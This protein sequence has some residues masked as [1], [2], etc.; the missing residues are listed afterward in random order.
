MGSLFINFNQQME[1]VT[2]K[3]HIKV[4]KSVQAPDK[5]T[6]TEVLFGEYTDDDQVLEAL[7]QLESQYADNP[8]YE[9]LHGLEDR[10]SL[11]FR[12]KDSQETISY[13]TE[14]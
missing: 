14:D 11:S 4:I 3:R 8:M 7:R 5:L 13:M 12:N 10:L 6:H 1:Q 9:K 2:N